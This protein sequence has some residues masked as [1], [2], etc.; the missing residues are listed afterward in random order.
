MI[1][2]SPFRRYT[3]G[4]FQI[5]VESVACIVAFIIFI[6]LVVLALEKKKAKME[7]KEYFFFFFVVLFSALAGGRLWYYITHW[8]GPS[9]LITMFNLS[10][11]GLVS[12]GVL[13]GGAIGLL[14]YSLN[15]PK[16]SK[17]NWQL[18][19]A[20]FA[21]VI[22][23]PAAL[24]FFIF[25]SIGCTIRGDIKGTPTDVPWCFLWTDGVCRHP[26]SVY[27]ALSALLVYIALMVYFRR[28]KTD[29]NKF[30][31]RFDGEVILWFLLLY[32]FNRFWIEFL[33][34]GKNVGAIKYAG[35]SIIQWG[36][37]VIIGYSFIALLANWY[38][39]RRLGL[40][41]L[42]QHHDFDRKFNI[43]SFFE[44]FRYIKEK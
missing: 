17:E 24:A 12:L 19:L 30:G 21:D 25:R 29:K 3:F 26:V 33:V 31:K 40:N 4:S 27:L 15:R 39:N 5:G 9:S 13:A 41:T 28:E 37:L 2:Y 23:A 8:K 43:K 20:R 36:C 38:V 11:P 7:V 22:A 34:V 6:V 10:K 14:I 18:E 44:Y 32:C 1:I 42:K 16:Q 35:L